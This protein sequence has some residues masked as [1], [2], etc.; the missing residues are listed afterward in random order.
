MIDKLIKLL[1]L[2]TSNH[3]GEALSAMR[4]ANEIIKQHGVLWDSVIYGPQMNQQ[5]RHESTSWES[6]KETRKD[7]IHRMLCEVLENLEEDSSAHEFVSSLYDFF[8]ARGFLTI[9]QTEALE[10]FYK[11]IH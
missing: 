6:A 11:N 9:K 7:R 3:D 10:K 5:K 4:K 2:T 1:N 8:N